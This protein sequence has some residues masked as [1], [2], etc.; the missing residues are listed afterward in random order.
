MIVSTPI[1]AKPIINTSSTSA[2]KRAWV[3]LTSAVH[4]V[5]VQYSHAW[6]N[7]TSTE[8]EISIKS[9]FNEIVHNKIQVM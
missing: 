5:P 1:V 8:E 4:A 7:F 2:H 9:K 3:N 6:V